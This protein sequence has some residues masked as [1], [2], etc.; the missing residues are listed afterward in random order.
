MRIPT[1]LLALAL[2]GACLPAHAADHALT[3]YGGLRDGGSFDD[4][5]SGRRLRLDGGASFAASLD[6]PLDASRQWQLY[7]SRQST[8]LSLDRATR[9]TADPSRLRLAITYLHIGGSNFFGGPQA[10]GAEGQGPYLAGG[11]GATLLQPRG[12][13]D[14]ELRPSMSLALGYQLPL[15]TNFALRLEARGYYTLVNSSGGLFCS[16]GCTLDIE[17]EG[18]AQGEVQLGLSV[19]F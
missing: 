3:I 11:I 8:D 2:A 9:A 4:S 15:G 19:R 12:G 6:L 17:G 5:A 16:G 13:Y 10:G 7:L 1:L 14:Q 18:F